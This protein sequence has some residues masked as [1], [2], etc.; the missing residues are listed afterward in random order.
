M[1]FYALAY[2]LR[3]I[4]TPLIANAFI[5]DL[6]KLVTNYSKSK[7]KAIINKSFNKESSEDNNSITKENFIALIKLE[8]YKKD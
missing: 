6:A 3:D 4:L 2:Y 8:E 1:S 5:V 7:Y